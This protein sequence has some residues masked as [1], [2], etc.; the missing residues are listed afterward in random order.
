MD[1][2]ARESIRVKLEQKDIMNVPATTGT[3]VSPTNSLVV[4]DRVQGI[5]APPERT[6]T[7]RN[8]LIP[9]LPHLTV[10]NSFRKR[11]LPIMLQLW[12]KVP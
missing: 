6:L 10:L 3:G 5:I 1:S 4:S 8:L 11:G 9:A 12:R 7:I 2:S